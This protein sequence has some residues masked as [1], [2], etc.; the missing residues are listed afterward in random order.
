MD[1]KIIGVGFQKTGTSTLREA[2]EIMGYRV[3]DTTPRALIP[4]LRGNEKK[5]MRMLNNFDAMEDTPWYRIY[6]DLDRMYPG[7]KFI[8]TKRD[9][10]SWYKSVSLHIGNLPAAHHEWIYGRG[11]G[12]V[13]LYPENTKSVYEKHNAE[14]IDYFKNRSE[15]LLVLNFTKGDGWK[16]LCGFLGREVPEY[17]FPHNNKTSDTIELRKRLS[18]KIRIQRQRIKNVLKI[19]YISLMGWWE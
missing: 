1:G 10:E 16:E 5:L 2:L 6:K 11:K 13:S 17:P 12:I 14:V 7:S 9:T 15:D 8:L 18:Y 19:W 3:K 4:I